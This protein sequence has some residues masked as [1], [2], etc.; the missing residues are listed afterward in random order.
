M[1]VKA[2]SIWFQEVKDLTRWQQLK[3]SGK[4]DAL[5][6]YQ[7][8][9]LSNRDAWQFLSPLSVKVLSYDAAK[10]QVNVEMETPGRMQG[11]KWFLDDG[12]LAR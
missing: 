7:E 2:N 6:D 1:E 12:T 5:A 10:R 4:S 8:K 3:K 11:T 9:L